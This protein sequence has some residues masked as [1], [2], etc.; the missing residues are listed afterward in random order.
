M[1]IALDESGI[2]LEFGM[3]NTD[4]M[5]VSETEV[6]IALGSEDSCLLSA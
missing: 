6:S 4:V 2:D 1:E 5:P 3:F